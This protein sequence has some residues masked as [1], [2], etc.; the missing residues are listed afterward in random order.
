MKSAD[1]DL[2][3]D[4][5]VGS[6][7]VLVFFCSILLA[8]AYHGHYGLSL[9][10]LL[11]LSYLAVSWLCFVVMRRVRLKSVYKLGRMW[12]WASL[13][14]GLW[15]RYG[16][17]MVFA[18]GRTITLA[19]LI[20][21]AVVGIL[22]SLTAEAPLWT[23]L[24]RVV[25]LLPVL[26]V[27]SPLV[28]G[29]WL[30]GPVVW[31]SDDMADKATATATVVLLFDELNAGAS[32]DLQRVLRG[33]GMQVGFKP[34]RPAYGSTTE[35]VPALFS[36]GD[37]KGAQPCGLTTICSK[38]TALDFSQVRV[39]RADVD[40]LGFAQPYCAI[41]GLRYCKRIFTSSLSL[42][43]PGRWTCAVQRIFNLDI[44]LQKHFCQELSHASW[45]LFRDK[46]LAELSGLPALKQGGVAYVHLPVP[47]PPAQGTG[48]LAEQYA[49]NLQ[50][51]EKILVDL[52]NQ[53]ASNGVEPRI[54]I[55]S[56]HIL[57]QALWCGRESRQFDVPCKV[58][59]SLVDDHV[60]LI[61]A[62]RSSLP[63][64]EDVQSNRQ[65]FDLLREW[66]KN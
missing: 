16:G 24:R 51:G 42:F 18:W 39:N 21:L 28:I 63:S 9:D 57:R 30:A 47:H 46:L 2:R 32:Q 52:L 14:M 8:K 27:S 66:L 12:L 5:A 36:A 25:G 60:P 19:A 64:I 44:E 37:F 10:D 13:L 38:T 43:D 34:V 48:T 65:V 58:D 1:R 20:A 23:R 59:P 7:A 35:A 3:W 6:C 50:L 54:V 40:V 11:P 22:L 41:Q 53:M 55:F 31:L 49:R 33:H 56:D 4:V 26:I 29:H 17:V 62:A 15:V 61:V 45:L